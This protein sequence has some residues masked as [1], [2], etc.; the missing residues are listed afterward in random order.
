MAMLWSEQ[1]KFAIMRDRNNDEVHC[2]QRISFVEQVSKLLSG[3]FLYNTDD[4]P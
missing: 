4:I 2:V 1:V 3:M